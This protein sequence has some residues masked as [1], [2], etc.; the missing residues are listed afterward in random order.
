GA[1]FARACATSLVLL[2]PAGTAHSGAQLAL[3]AVVA[4]S[5]QVSVRNH[6]ASIELSEA[7]VARGYVDVATGPHV[8]VT[9][10]S[11]DG[12]VV[13]FLAAGEIFRA[14]QLRGMAG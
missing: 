2:A 8:D 4:K 3:S 10:N 5:A 13:T 9:T 14:V 6:P 12:L 7:D 11:R 1:M